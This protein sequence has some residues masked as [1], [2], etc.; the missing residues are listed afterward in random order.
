MFRISRAR[1]AGGG[2]N[3]HRLS[4]LGNTFPVIGVQNMDGMSISFQTTMRA[5]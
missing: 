1:E 3:C 5:A 4:L 2:G